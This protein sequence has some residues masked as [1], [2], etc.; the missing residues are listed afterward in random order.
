V[1]L[2]ERDYQGAGDNCLMYSFTICTLHQM[3]LL[4]C[5]SFRGMAFE[6]LGTFNI[7]TVDQCSTLGDG[8]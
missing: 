8:F 2:R 3:L 4:M 5:P 7:F 6:G 1:G